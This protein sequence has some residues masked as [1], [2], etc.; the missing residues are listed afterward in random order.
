MKS[1]WFQLDNDIILDAIE[2]PYLG[3]THVELDDMFLPAGINGGWYRWDG[4]AYHFDQALYDYWMALI[5][6]EN[7][8]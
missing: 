3:Y 4:T 1:Y 7:N 2:Y 6:A 8:A 5:E